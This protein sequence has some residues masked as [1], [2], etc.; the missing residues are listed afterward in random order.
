MGQG[1]QIESEREQGAGTR[2]AW[3]N[4]TWFVAL[5]VLGSMVP[6]LWPSLPPLL[7][8]PG[9]LARYH[10]QLSLDGSPWL[11]RYYEF[12]CAPVGNL[13]VD[14]LVEVI[15]PLV[16]L[17]L[18]V[19]LVVLAIPA[20]FVGGL[21]A[22]AREVH[23]RLPPTAALAAPLAYATPFLYGFLNFS[24]SVA[25]AL[26][27]FAWWLRLA[28]LGRRR[29][30][31][32]LFM[33]VSLLLYFTHIYGWGVLGL[34]CFGAELVASRDRR[35]RGWPSALISSAVAC[36]VLA[37]PLIPLLGAI[38]N[39]GGGSFTG[40]FDLPLKFRWLVA[41]LRDRW[42]WLDLPA[43]M[44]LFAAL[45]FARIDP[46]LHFAQPLAA[47]AV[48][49]SLACLVLPFYMLNSALADM[50][51]LP[52]LLAVAIVAIDSDRSDRRFAARLAI[53]ATLFFVVRTATQSA[54][55]A[56]AGR[57]QDERLDQLDQLPQGAR[58]VA[59]VGRDCDDSWAAVR[60]GHLASMVTVR[61]DGF[62]NDQWPGQGINL[63]RLRYRPPGPF[64][65]DPSEMVQPAACVT[66]WTVDQALSALPRPWF[67][68]VW[69]LGTE[70]PR[71]A[72]FHGLRLV[73]QSADASLYR[74]E[75]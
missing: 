25:L 61:R 55:F 63:L 44:L 57:Q 72:Q 65:T 2:H 21:L 12:H 10:V 64:A 39:A 38:R 41:P 47:G 26:L 45:L 4:S 50:R 68:Y 6:L 53:A 11:Q 36:L 14:L 35:G 40:W 15:A 27:A 73:A 56:L 46:R 8:L 23:G 34:L 16:G 31:G 1:G 52:V 7:D 71:P 17:E 59:L 19:K 5:L 30:R 49:M 48:L 13:G 33:P 42:K 62:S 54:S 9:H 69:L 51:L 67:D 58:V 3:W 24:L 22:I 18:G 32:I 75:R 74:I 70:P 60:D 37:A 66:N 20:L 28:R 43:G 29:L